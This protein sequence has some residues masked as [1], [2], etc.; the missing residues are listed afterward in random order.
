M[1]KPFREGLFTWP[2]EEGEETSLIGSRCNLCK[3]TFFP[4]LT[5]CPFCFHEDSTGQVFLSHR[6]K[7][8]TYSIVRQAGPRYQ[9]PYIVAY[10]AL[11][12]GLRVFSQVT[13]CLPEDLEIGMEMEVILQELR[14]DENGNRLIGYKFRPVKNLGK[15]GKV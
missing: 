5:I 14:V 9:V 7:L 11:P 6:G 2:L 10:I 1:V 3:K 12:E 8:E 15:E 13:E 4:P